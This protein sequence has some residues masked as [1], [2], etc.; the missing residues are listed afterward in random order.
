MVYTNEPEELQDLLEIAYGKIK[1]NILEWKRI[2]EYLIPQLLMFSPAIPLSSHGGKGEWK[3]TF[4]GKVNG[5]SYGPVFWTEGKV[6][7]ERAEIVSN[8]WYNL[9]SHRLYGF[10][11]EIYATESDQWEQ[12]RSWQAVDR[13]LEIEQRLQDLGLDQAGRLEY[14]ACR[15]GFQFGETAEML[16]RLG[17]NKSLE[18]VRKSFG[19]VKERLYNLSRGS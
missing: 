8:D 1:A 10:I 2:P 4:E 16:K 19:R 11:S 6:S 9:Q 7:K 17:V 3:A 5:P 14:Y 18:A 12:T 13:Q 15:L